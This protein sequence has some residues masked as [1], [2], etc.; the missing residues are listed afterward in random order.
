MAYA[1]GVVIMGIGL[2]QV[3]EIYTSLVVQ[4]I[5]GNYKKK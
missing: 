1:V 2:Q 3:E 5:R 4:K